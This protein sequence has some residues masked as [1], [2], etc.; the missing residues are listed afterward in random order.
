MGQN[1]INS[2]GVTSWHPPLP[3]A[4]LRSALAGIG[5][6]AVAAAGAAA[7]FDPRRPSGMR[8]MEHVL[9]KAGPSG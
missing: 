8:R 6:E 4:A 2:T 1:D 9:Q 5:A 3:H 7:G